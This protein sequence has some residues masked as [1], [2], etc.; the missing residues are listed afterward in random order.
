M[1]NYKRLTLKEREEI[2]RLLAVGLSLTS[3]AKSL[4]RATSTV[5]R[6]ITSSGVVHVQYYRAV[7]A[8]QRVNKARRKIRKNRKLDNN[9]AL[10]EFV[11]SHLRDNWSPEQIAKR[12]VLLY[13]NDMDLRISH[14]IVTQI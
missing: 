3:I 13:P 5:S 9:K 12:L 4:V 2:S 8:Q 14:E 6:E 1:Q 10:R 7:F 11:F